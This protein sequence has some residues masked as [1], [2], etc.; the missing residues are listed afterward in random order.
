MLFSAFAIAE[1]NNF[2]IMLEAYLGLYSRIA[3]EELLNEYNVSA[4][5]GDHKIA[6]TSESV[7]YR[8]AYAT[9]LLPLSGYGSANK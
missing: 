6:I 7:R 4:I 1:S 3:F 2:L 8:K 9:Q 5:D